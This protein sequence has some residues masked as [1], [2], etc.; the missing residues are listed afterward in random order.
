MCGPLIVRCIRNYSFLSVTGTL[1]E[2][3]YFKKDGPG[4][5]AVR[6]IIHASV[7]RAVAILAAISRSVISGFP[8]ADTCD[9]FVMRLGPLPMAGTS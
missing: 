4:L 2:S 7:V 9:L 5:K 8:A 3:S 1:T 6:S